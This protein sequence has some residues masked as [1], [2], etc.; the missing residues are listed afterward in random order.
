LHK[1]LNLPQPD[2]TA[3]SGT[4]FVSGTGK[5]FV[6]L[7]NDVTRADIRQALAEGYD[8]IE[9]TKRYTTLGMGTDQ[10]KTSWTNG[11]L[12]IARRSNQ[13]AEAIGHTTYRP[14]YSPVTI[15]ALVGAEIGTAMTPVRRTPFHNG[16]KQMGCVF[17]TS[18]D[19]LYSRYF[20]LGDENMTRAIQ[21]ECNA[22]RNKLGCVDMS[23]LGKFDVQGADALEF[24][25]RLYCNNFAT[26]KTGQLRY[27][28]M[29]REDGIVFDDGTIARLG[30]HHFVTT[31]TTANTTSVWRHMQKLL[32]I[33]WPALDVVLTDVTDQWASLAIAGPDARKMLTALDPNFATD[34]ESFPFACV[35]EGELPDGMPVRIFS[36]SFSGELSFEINTPAGYADSLLKRVM[37]L[38]DEWDITPYGLETLDVLRIEKGHLAVGTEIDGRRTPADLGMGAMVSKKKDFVGRALLQRPA[39]QASGRA[40]LV[41][42]EPE[43][44]ITPIP[45]AAH[46]SNTPLSEDGTAESLGYL[47]ASVSVTTLAHPIALAFLKDGS[48][49]MGEVLWAHSPAAN[50]SVRVRVTPSCAYDPKGERV[51]AG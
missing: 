6:D 31:A 14:P 22:V 20:P 11:L 23:T 15:G 5:A 42:L 10:G 44:G 40:A 9:L 12:E 47:T 46:L 28:L 25:S 16:F 8:D 3:H 13:P 38:G 43:D 51:H 1:H 49:R 4:T 41:G 27:G 24:L 39:L 18:G 34:L 17:Q 2:P 50:T 36:V 37:E 19:W 33:D 35:R 45:F 29:L 48:N 32:Q 21:R 7:Q 30:E 26:I